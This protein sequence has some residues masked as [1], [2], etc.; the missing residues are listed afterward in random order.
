MNLRRFQIRRRFGVRAASS[1][2]VLRELERLNRETEKDFLRLGGRL[3]EFQQASA[4]LASRLHAV[5]GLWSGTDA[6][7][8]REVLAEVLSQS[9]SMLASAGD[10][11]FALVAVKSAAD[12]VAEV[13]AGYERT[14]ATFRLLGTLIRIETARLGDQST[15]IGYLADEVQQLAGSIRLRVEEALERAGDLDRRI[16]AA[17]K[18]AIDLESRELRQIPSLIE[19]V[20]AGMNIV[21]TRREDAIRTSGLLGDRYGAL[22]NAMGELVTALQFHDITRQRVEHVIEALSAPLA[23]AAVCKLQEAQLAAAEESFAESATCIRSRLAEMAQ[24]IEEM[25]A[26]GESLLDRDSAGRDPVLDSLEKSFRAIS[27]ALQ[28]GAASERAADGTA[29][30]LLNLTE[31]LRSVAEGISAIDLQMHRLALN[32][33]IRAVQIGAGGDAL[34]A[35]AQ[36]LQELASSSCSQSVNV[37]TV[38]DAM[39]RAAAGLQAVAGNRGNAERPILDDL[40]VCIQHMNEAARHASQGGAAIAGLARRL[41]TEISRARETFTV[42]RQFT[43]GI[44]R[45]RRELRAKAAPTGNVRPE[46][47]KCSARYTMHA[48]RAVHSAVGRTLAV[49]K[50]GADPGSDKSLGENVEMF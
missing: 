6:E 13:F 5:A 9:E 30:E 37:A 31:E 42:D 32:A 46:L 12:Q 15:D 7:R 23:D 3:Q 27:N 41:R 47:E 25:I 43:S 19:R 44:A 28:D 1:P 22:T 10:I 11:S 20:T 34:S 40:R 24:Q 2:G 26:E 8:S 38:L 17:L 18:N 16:H 48:E 50:A 45:C 14:V 4:D 21:Q 33:G 49:P 35:L 36:S 29:G 39:E